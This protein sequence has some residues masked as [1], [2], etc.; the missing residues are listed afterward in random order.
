MNSIARSL[1]FIL[2]AQVFAMLTDS[3]GWSRV[4][5][6]IAPQNLRSIRL[7]ERL[8]ERFERTLMLRGHE[9]S[10]ARARRLARPLNDPAVTLSG[11][12]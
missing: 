3:L 8:G 2:F 5:S 7:A 10:C 9:V 6:L 1:F 11:T 12:R 4:T